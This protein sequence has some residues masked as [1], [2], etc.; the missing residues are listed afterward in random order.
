MDA[1]QLRAALGQFTG[2]VNFTRHGIARS[3]LMT[4]S[5]VFL[6]E[7]AG[8]HWLT[9]V[10]VSWQCDPNVR[11]ELFQVRR[12]SVP[13]GTTSGSVQMFDGNGKEPKVAQA[14][15]YIDFPLPEMELWLE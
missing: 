3:V 11:G 9:D 2:S 10:T 14:L 6:A 1:D 12:L 5:V 8:A 7:K 13:A 15:P 4:E